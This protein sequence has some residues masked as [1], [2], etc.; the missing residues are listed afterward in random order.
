M[1]ATG[2][3][4]NA[5]ALKPTR[6]MSNSYPMLRRLSKTCDGSH[7][8]QPLIA[9]RAAA[10]AFYPTEL[11]RAILHGMVDTADAQGVGSQLAEDDYDAHLTISI[12]RQAPK[13]TYLSKRATMTRYVL[14]V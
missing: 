3:G 6:F 2:N 4:H 7:A 10:A 8:H 14:P 12:H 11:I 9:R 5:H 1:S 13:P